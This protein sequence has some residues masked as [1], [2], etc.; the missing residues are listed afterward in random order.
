MKNVHDKVSKAIPT[1]T[2]GLYV[3]SNSD[4]IN[5]V[6]IKVA[7]RTLSVF[8]RACTGVLTTIKPE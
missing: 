4:V 8:C 5:M 3:N 7:T 2:Q 6:Y 1:V